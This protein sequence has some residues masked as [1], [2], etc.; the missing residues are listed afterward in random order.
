MLPKDGL[1]ATEG[2][3]SVKL[4]PEQKKDQLKGQAV[5][6]E[7]WDQLTVRGKEGGGERVNVLGDEEPCEK[8]EHKKI[9]S[10]KFFQIQCQ[11][12]AGRI[13]AACQCVEAV[14]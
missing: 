10:G 6:G 3:V 13:L 8:S 2:E 5:T 1:N 11:V 9:K 4:L 12:S 7:M 14:Q